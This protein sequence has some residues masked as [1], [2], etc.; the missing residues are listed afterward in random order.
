VLALGLALVGSLGLLAALVRLLRLPFQLLRNLVE[1]AFQL[2][3]TLLRMLSGRAAPEEP[4]ADAPAHPGSSTSQATP[5]EPS[6][7]GHQPQDAEPGIEFEETVSR[8][9][10]I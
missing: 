6:P 9:R 1:V 2:T 7:D 4:E 3:L 8:W 5:T 10:P